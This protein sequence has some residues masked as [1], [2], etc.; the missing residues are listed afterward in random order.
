MGEVRKIFFLYGTIFGV[1]YVLLDV[2][3]G[4]PLTAWWVDVLTGYAAAGLAAASMYVASKR[5][6]SGS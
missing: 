3:R 1:G 2:I 6:R 5:N 4:D